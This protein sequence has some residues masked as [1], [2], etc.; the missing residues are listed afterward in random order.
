MKISFSIKL[1]YWL[2]YNLRIRTWK[3]YSMPSSSASFHI[4]VTF[5]HGRIIM[6]TLVYYGVGP[7]LI[8]GYAWM[9]T[10]N[11]TRGHVCLHVSLSCHQKSCD[12][13][14]TSLP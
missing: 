9:A 14:S 3:L 6:A 11:N 13:E 8:H 5:I 10:Q 2:T 4:L 1:M 12:T 7:L